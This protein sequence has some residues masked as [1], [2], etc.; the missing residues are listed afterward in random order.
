MTL[1]LQCRIRNPGLILTVVHSA[2][3][4]P[5]YNSLAPGAYQKELKHIAAY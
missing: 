3:V 1:V 4:M 5:H 2:F